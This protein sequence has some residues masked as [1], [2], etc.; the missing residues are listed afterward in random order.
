MQSGR[1]KGK[2]IQWDDERGFGFIAPESGGSRI[3][4]HI[5][6][7]RNASRRPAADDVLLFDI[8]TQADG[9][10]RATNASIQGLPLSTF[11]PAPRYAPTS[12]SRNMEFSTWA[13]LLLAAL[14]GAFIYGAW[15]AQ[16][17]PSLASA[18]LSQRA[19][20]N[21][22]ARPREVV[23]APQA[24]S[25]PKQAKK[26]PVDTPQTPQ[27]ITETPHSDAE[28][29]PVDVKTPENVEEI[30]EG[31]AVPAEASEGLI[32]GNISVKTGEKLYH[33]PDM[34]DYNITIIDPA[35]GERY[36]K[37]EQEAIDAGWRR[38]IPK[39]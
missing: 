37:T 16:R 32:K 33:T 14:G 12:R 5:R 26:K 8:E 2:L 31:S 9:R 35:K 17:E 3:F 15:Q 29:P 27:Y 36:F 34:R 25:S 6:A 24:R 23:V 21:S 11:P 18:P 39:R 20:S 28:K 4:V 19:L 7:I 38:A 13:M 10:L 30:S 1:F 22:S